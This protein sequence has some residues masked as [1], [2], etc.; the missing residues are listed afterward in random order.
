MTGAQAVRAVLDLLTRAAN[1]RNAGALRWPVMASVA[2]DG[3]ADARMLVLRR[4]DRGGRRLELHTDR[5]AP[6]TAQLAAAP[7]CA[8][9]FFDA[10]SSVQLRV[11][12]SAKVHSG[13]EAA[14]TAF[15][16]AP[17]RSLQDY[18]GAPPGARLEADAPSS[19]DAWSNFAAIEITI[20]TVDWLK[21]S[22][23]GHERWRVDFTGPEPV[24]APVAP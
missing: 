16:R 20:E 15:N 4:F 10:R 8:L 22:R 11:R 13:N 24:A 21:L 6:K 18:R 12:G 23:D 17:E 1:D 5:R 14:R 19:K 9:V 3:G 2:S 7:S